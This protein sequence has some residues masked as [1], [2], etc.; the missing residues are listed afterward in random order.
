MVDWVLGK[1]YLDLI[2]VINL[3]LMMFWK[4]GCVEDLIELFFDWFE[5]YDKVDLDE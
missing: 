4:L 3:F 1:M 5:V 2:L